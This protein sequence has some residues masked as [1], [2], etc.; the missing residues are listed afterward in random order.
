[1]EI[2]S[3][4]ARGGLEPVEFGY[5]TQADFKKIV[6]SESIKTNSTRDDQLSDKGPNPE[7]CPIQ[8]K[9]KTT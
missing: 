9:I 6:D 2:Q 4:R 8:G 1:M 7:S 3:R 5:L